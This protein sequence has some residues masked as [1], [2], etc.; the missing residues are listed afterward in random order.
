MATASSMVPPAGLA[1]PGHAASPSGAPGPSSAPEPGG[2][3]GPGDALPR[4]GSP[5]PGASL[6]SGRLRASA[7]ALDGPTGR[8]PA[9]S[10]EQGGRLRRLRVLGPRQSLRT[11]LIL[12]FAAI[13]F[14]TLLVVGIGFIF[15]LRQ[16]Q[17]QREILRLSGLAGPVAFQARSLEQQDA[18]V[19]E[20]TDF[21]Q[22]LADDLDVRIVL[23]SRQGAIFFDSD[24]ALEGQRLDLQGAQ[25]IGPLR[26]A[27]LVS[28]GA[29]DDRR[30]F[31]IAAAALERSPGRLGGG[32]VLALVSEPMT[33]KAVLQELAPR[34]ALAALVSLLASIVV[35][36][37]LAAS[38]ASPLARMT[39]AAEEI[40]QGR[41]DQ[42]IPSHG[43]DEIGRLAAAFN[44]MA[45]AVA[46][47]QR[48][49]RDFVANVSHDL[50]TPLTSVQ[51]FS[52]AMVDGA[53]RTPQEYAEAGQVINDEAA[54]MRRLVEDLL[55]LSKIESGQIRLERASVDLAMFARQAAER[56]ERQAS[57]RGLTVITTIDGAPTVSADCRWLERALDNLL[58]NAVKHTPA[59]GTISLAVGT[60]G[61]WPLDGRGVAPSTWA[62]LSVHNTGS[63]IPPEDRPR[64]FERFYQLDKARS[65]SNGSSG[66]GLAIAQEIVQAHN[67]RIEVYSS[68]AD[69]TD[70]VV[71]LPLLDRSGDR[72]VGSTLPVRGVTP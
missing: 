70:F 69:G 51:G 12:A 67:G 8:L 43:S 30:I 31:F 60:L 1:L 3:P 50:R 59:D 11:R 10:P 45:F 55:Q 71:T 19:A 53:L 62:Y 16:Y 49:L 58:D 6:A 26:R 40:A 25:R 33:L 4:V 52:Q 46:R 29:G 32:Y 18:N 65:G 42:S 28:T 22:R 61:R 68:A 64:V 34:L 24:N 41:Y 56:I 72:E 15:I 38:I 14:L 47:S 35:A 13:I 5:A 48:T 17:E 39:R 9:V 20:I 21:L 44:S 23:S 37:V 66:L 36:W 27:R 63:F 7:P 2:A 54:R 57:E